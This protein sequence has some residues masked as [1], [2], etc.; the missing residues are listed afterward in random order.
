MNEKRSEI[1]DILDELRK[2]AI[3]DP[4]P[5]HDFYVS[6]FNLD[7]LTNRKWY[8]VEETHPNHNW[9]SKFTLGILRFAV[10][11]AW[12]YG[13]KGQYLPWLDWRKEIAQILYNY[14]S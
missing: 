13:T 1:N 11:D 3:P 10:Y 5:L 14:G 12:V 9:K 8:A 2:P 6:H 7:D 4:A